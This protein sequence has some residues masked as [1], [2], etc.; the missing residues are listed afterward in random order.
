M[1]KLPKPVSKYLTKR[2]FEQ[3]DSSY[4]KILDKNGNFFFGFFCYIKNENI[5][6][7]VLITEK[8]IINHISNNTIE[9]SLNNEKK[10]IELGEIIFKN[11]IYD[12]AIIEIKEKMIANLKFL[13]LGRKIIQKK[14]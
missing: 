14:F 4:Y 10:N 9:I 13:E 7:P 5:N 3:M 8:Q 1:E 12:I 6:I 11:N 2:I